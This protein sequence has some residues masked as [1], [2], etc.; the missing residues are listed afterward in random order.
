[1]KRIKLFPIQF[2][3]LTL[4]GSL[5]LGLSACSKKISFSKSSIVPAAEGKVK[6]KKDKNNN[7]SVSVSVDNLAQPKDLTPSRSTYVVWMETPGNATKNIGQLNTSGGFLSKGRKST[8][9]TQGCWCWKG[10]LECVQGY[11]P[12]KQPSRNGRHGKF[13]CICLTRKVNFHSSH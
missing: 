2:I 4:A 7:Y 8:T 5:I 12:F 10:V 9:N 1:M 11:G 13:H 3:L 6:V